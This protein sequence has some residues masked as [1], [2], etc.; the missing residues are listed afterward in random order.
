MRADPALAKG[1][2]VYGGTIT[3]AAVAEAHGLTSASL[4]SVIDGAPD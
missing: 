2:N 4:S 3:T 1:V